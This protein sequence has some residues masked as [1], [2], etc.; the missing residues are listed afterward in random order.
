VLK[1]NSDGS[2]VILFAPTTPDLTLTVSWR[3]SADS[4]NSDETARCTATRVE[5]LPVLSAAPSRAIR[6]PG[7]RCEFVTFAIAPA[8][9]RPNLSPLEISI[10]S[11][12][13]VRYPRARERLRAM[14]IPMRVEEQVKYRT[15]LP[16][17]ANATFAQLCRFWW[18][19]CGPANAHVGQLNLNNRGRPDLDGSNSILRSLAR[20]QPARWAFGFDVRVRQ[21][22]RLLARVRRAGRCVQ[23][24]RSSGLFHRCTVARGSTLLR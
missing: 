5:T 7:S 17:L 6:Q 13:R 9:R 3:Q 11:T 4:S 1:E 15:R 10:R 19:I 23:V 12:S 22:G 21:A 2:G 20:T 14:V 24:R 18:L 16:R 8:P